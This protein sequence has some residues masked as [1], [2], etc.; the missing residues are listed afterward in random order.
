MNT[1]IL[2]NPITAEVKQSIAA[3]SNELLI[4][5]PFLSG[6]AATILTQSE[7][8]QF[9]SKRLLVRFDD[10]SLSSYD[11]ATMRYLLQLG[12][13]IRFE[14]SIHLK[15]YLVD[16]EAYLTSSN[17][18]Q[19]GFEKNIELTAK[20][21]GKAVLDCKA[22]F[23]KLWN[24][25]ADNVVTDALIDENWSKYLV[26]VARAKNNS[27]SQ[28]STWNAD[29]APNQ[30]DQP[31]LFKAI[32]E[33]HENFSYLKPKEIEANEKREETK[34]LLLK[35]FDPLIFYA[36]KGNSKRHETLF[37]SF[38]YGLESWLAGTGLYEH[39]Y[40]RVFLDTEF[41]QVIQFIFPEMM[42]MTPWHLNDSHELEAFCKGLF[43]FRIPAFKKVIP[44][45]L[46]T[47]FYPESFLPIFNLVHLESICV[48]F[49]HTA[50][51]GGVGD[52]FKSYNSWLQED[53]KVLAST[54][55]VK[56]RI[57][58]QALYAIELFGRLKNGETMDSI[59]DGTRKQWIKGY[60][61]SGENILKRIGLI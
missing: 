57:A 56:S 7:I 11:L 24:A 58:Y 21:D 22:I 51:S 55:A 27:T 46:A 17:L 60:Y 35:G 14:N 25:A 31:S 32:L 48:A 38:V 53:L 36:A 19:G 16:E 26:L 39:Q 23:E 4:A 2:Q 10:R 59:K 41:I 43:Q 5:V 30:I 28:R 34:R 18:T 54:N 29:I 37:Y 42:G 13:E 1:L 33:E 47:F 6:F 40:R 45:R 8:T 15:L 3:G 50:I 52:K 61:N 49:G 44:I 20:L 9:K 12:I